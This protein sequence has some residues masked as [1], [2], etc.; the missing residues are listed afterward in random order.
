MG[1]IEESARTLGRMLKES[2]EYKKFGKASDSLENDEELKS[3]I[4]SVAEKERALN[5][6]ME[7]AIPVEVEEKRNLKELKDKAQ[8]NAV[9]A[10]FLEA[11]KAYFA[12]MKR[13]NDAVNEALKDESAPSESS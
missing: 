1:E 2:P 8:A 5:E 10:E 11:E 13:V 7:K 4:N 9:S 3:L 12:L 6:K